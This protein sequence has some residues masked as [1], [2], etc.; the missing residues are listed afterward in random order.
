MQLELPGHFISNIG[1]AKVVLQER[2]R[3]VQYFLHFLTRRLHSSIDHGYAD[4]ASVLLRRK[5]DI[6]AAIK[7][8]CGILQPMYWQYNKLLAIETNMKR[9]GTGDFFKEQG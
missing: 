5:T 6:A 3:P 2:K 7:H 8:N 9:T 1:L 4:I